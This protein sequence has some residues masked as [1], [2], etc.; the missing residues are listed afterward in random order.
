MKY[1]S[2]SKDPLPEWATQ[3]QSKVGNPSQ[4]KE[5]ELHK[6]VVEAKMSAPL[7]KSIGDMT[8]I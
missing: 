4:M 2:W 7:L 3:L 5:A 1:I 8:V 6:E